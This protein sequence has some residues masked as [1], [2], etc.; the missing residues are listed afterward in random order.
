MYTP[1]KIIL[2][3]LKFDKIVSKQDIKKAIN[4]LNTQLI[5]NYSQVARDFGIKYT[6]LI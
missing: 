6:I 5:P 4:I 1:L 2:L 3:S